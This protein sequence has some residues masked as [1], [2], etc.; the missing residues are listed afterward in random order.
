L[1]FHPFAETLRHRLSANDHRPTRLPAPLSDECVTPESKSAYRA[2]DKV[3]A[4]AAAG[5]NFG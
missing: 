2:R 4:G 1:A 5:I 3:I